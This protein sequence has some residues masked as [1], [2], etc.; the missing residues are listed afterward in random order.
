MSFYNM[1]K[2]VN[3]AAFMFLPML[4]KHPTEYPRFRDC[5][6]GDDKRPEYEDHIIIYTRTGGGN[7]QDYIEENNEMRSM[8]GFVHDYDDDFDE[9]YASWVFQIP[10]RWKSDYDAFV[11]GRINDVSQ[12]YRDEMVRVYPKLKEKFSEIFKEKTVDGVE[13]T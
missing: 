6:I 10:E 5:F 11:S 9:T 2:G 3:P 12:E 7:R 1:V 4:G 8:S 13:V